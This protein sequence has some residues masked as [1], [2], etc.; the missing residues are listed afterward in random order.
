MMK[1]I[2]QRLFVFAASIAPGLFLL[3]YNIGTGSVT[4]MATSGS[5]YG[6][7][8]T[9]ALLLSCIFTYF[10]IVA[11]GKYTIVT[12]KTALQSFKER[13]GRTITLFILASLVVS[14]L[15]SC[16][17]IMGVITQVI[18]EWSKP[19]TASGEGFHP[20]YTGLFFSMI[21]IFLIWQGRY[22]FFE[23]VL[24]V[25][26]GLMAACFLMTMFITSPEPSEYLKGI[27]PSIPKEKNGLLIISGMVGTTMGGILYVVRSI[28]VSEKGWTLRDLRFEKR[29]AAVSASLMFLLSLAVM[30]CAAGTLFPK[31]IQINNAIDMVQMMEPLAGKFAASIFV[32]GIVSAGLSSLFPILLLAPWLLADFRGEK[33]NLTSGS[34]RALVLMGIV[35]SMTIPVFGGR[36]VFI[37]IA[38]QSLTIIATPLVLIL[39]MVL[40]NDKGLM[41]KYRFTTIQNVIMSIIIL[42]TVYIASVGILGFIS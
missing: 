9:W 31:G 11:F 6:M 42:F 7:K 8:L 12:G 20:V 19:L 1:S 26:V 36:P 30:A 29:D 5:R 25:F 32:F 24:A 33:S 18:Q 22:A 21:L 34:S 28:L 23:K 4:T 13:F 41:G 10:L 17:G 15:A 40:L 2:K 38:S 14:E 39:I 35:I 3:G 16:M 37:M 27:F